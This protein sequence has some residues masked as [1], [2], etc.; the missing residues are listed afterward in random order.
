LFS[1]KSYGETGSSSTTYSTP[2]VTGGSTG[3][4]EGV[5]QPIYS[6]YGHA[7]P[8]DDGQGLA[9]MASAYGVPSTE[10]S[11]DVKLWNLTVS[12]PNE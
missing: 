12:N 9:Y 2:A 6:S 11:K 10:D 7:Q 1:Q 5:Y 4:S 3:H 8:A